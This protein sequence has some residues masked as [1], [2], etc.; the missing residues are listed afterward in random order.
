MDTSTGGRQWKP[1]I[2]R[3]LGRAKHRTAR[4]D[5]GRVRRGPRGMRRGPRDCKTFFHNRLRQGSPSGWEDFDAGSNPAPC[6]Q[7]GAAT[8]ER[9]PRGTD[10]AT[11]FPAPP[12]LQE[13]GSPEAA[14]E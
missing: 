4:V 14:T 10:R 8:S 3:N 1:L 5:A 7:E 12:P 9:P 2:L 6:R 13:C 11:G